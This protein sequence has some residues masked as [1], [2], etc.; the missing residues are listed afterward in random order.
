MQFCCSPP[1]VQPDGFVDDGTLAVV[2]ISTT[3][4]SKVSRRSAVSS[5]SQ[6]QSSPTAN[7]LTFP[8]AGVSV[9]VLRS[10]AVWSRWEEAHRSEGKKPV[11]ALSTSVICS[12][13]ILP[14]TQ[15][16]QTSFVELLNIQPLTSKRGPSDTGLATHFISHTWKLSFRE[17]LSAIEAFIVE[18]H[19]GKEEDL[20]FWMD[21]LSVNQH[22]A[23][24]NMY[25]QNWWSNTFAT[26]IREIG[27][28]VLVVSPFNDPLAFKR[29]WCLW[30]I[31]SSVSTGARLTMQVS[32]QEREKFHNSF[33]STEENPVRNLL[34][35]IE[36]I[37]VR[38]ARAWKKEDQQM[39]LETVDTTV[40]TEWLNTVVKQKI[41]QECVNETLLLVRQ[42]IAAG[43][44]RQVL[45]NPDV[46]TMT[47]MIDLGLG[48]EGTEI[49]NILCNHYEDIEAGLPYTAPTLRAILIL[50]CCTTKKKEVERMEFLKRVVRS[51]VQQFG[52]RSAV[53]LDSSLRLSHQLIINNDEQ[54]ACNVLFSALQASL[55]GT[56][57][58]TQAMV[59][60]LNI[61]AA[62][63]LALST[64]EDPAKAISA[65][66]IMRDV[67]DAVESISIRPDIQQKSNANEIIFPVL[68]AK[69]NLAR[70]I[71][72]KLVATD[73]ME[74]IDSQ[75]HERLLAAHTDA[76]ELLRSVKDISIEQI[77]KLESTIKKRKFQRFRK[78]AI[79][80]ITAHW[81]QMFTQVK[82]DSVSALL[83]L[84]KN[85]YQAESAEISKECAELETKLKT[86]STHKKRESLRSRANRHRTLGHWGKREDG[87]Q[88]EDRRTSLSSSVYSVGQTSSAYD[89]SYDTSGGRN[90]FDT[91]GARRSFT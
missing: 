27:H 83:F 55:Q 66:Q 54:E 19:N 64:C 60:A 72:K 3:K 77:A 4:H 17:T 78:V 49:T 51:C 86:A 18:H 82:L 80:Q 33:R 53:G 69:M 38:K 35:A 29:S 52:A 9:S 12:Q 73:S 47:Q 21:I 63:F 1:A 48:V 85:K 10:L 59:E 5:R 8:R 90:S 20:Y 37:D 24:N 22:H 62:H 44:I 45:E 89:S 26:G 11:G 30:E 32:K 2:G 84:L 41:T 88:T 61:S 13:A 7:C 65:C 79:G 67:K 34:S 87:E 46:L 6:M 81:L 36:N 14:L 76:T 71:S 42:Q 31:Y 39:I 58:R 70:A 68:I 74:N 15:E 75:E 28:T 56:P 40:T 91:S 25:D 57:E 16:T 23:N 50:L 43:Q